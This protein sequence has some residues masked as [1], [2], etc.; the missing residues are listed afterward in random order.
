MRTGWVLALLLTGACSSKPTAEER[1]REGAKL[2][3]SACA[4]CHGTDGKGGAR[5]DAGRAPRNFHDADFHA[6]R[7]DEELKRVILDGKDTTMPA[8]RGKFTDAQ[9]TQLVAHLRSFDPRP[10]P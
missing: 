4:R 10:R 1:A 8:Y 9:L 5:P 7:T 6:S 2:Y 3:A